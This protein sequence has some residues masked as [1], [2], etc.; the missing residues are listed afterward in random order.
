MTLICLPVFVRLGLYR[1]VVRYMG[2]HAMV[3]VVQG[4][5]ITAIGIS[6]VA[7]MTP[8]KGFPRSVPIIFW[9]IAF[10]YVG[11][12]RFAVRSYFSWIAQRFVQRRLSSF[13]ARARAASNSRGRSCNKVITCRLRFSTTIRCC[14]GGRSTVSTCIRRMRWPALLRDT[15]AREVLVAVPSTAGDERKRIIEFLE[16]FAVHVRLVPDLAD[17]MAGQT[18]ANMRDVA[19][20][21]LLGRDAVAPLPHLMYALCARLRRARHRCRR[22]D[23]L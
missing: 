5:T 2:N 10:A 15:Q 3:A 18:V 16:P 17:L 20:E 12:S 11:G 6:L 1:Q 13:T 7:Y 23:R 19:P 8:L 22:L 9:L 21:D 14:S 4:V